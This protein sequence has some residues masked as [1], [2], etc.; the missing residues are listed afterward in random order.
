MQIAKSILLTFTLLGLIKDVDGQPGLNEKPNIIVFFTDDQGYGDVG[1]YGA[2]GIETPNF[3]QL[4]RDGIRFTDFYVPATVCTP[5]R[6][7]ILTG[8]YPKRVNLHESV[9]FPF[10]QNGLAP[11]EITLAEM[12]KDQG[13]STSCIGKWH[14]G[15]D[16][17]L[18]YFT[19]K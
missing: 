16:L 12:L 10:S 5:S 13:Y 19:D 11:K 2:E 9:I 7:A 15:Q 14:L 1:C 6:A 18:Y 17:N 8:K 4:A 3:D